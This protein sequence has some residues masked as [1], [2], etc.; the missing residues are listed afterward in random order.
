VAKN[1]RDVPDKEAKAF[2]AI[3]QAFPRLI[4]FSHVESSMREKKAR[5]SGNVTTVRYSSLNE[6]H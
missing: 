3:S 2:F 6:G 5:V 4:R 1:L